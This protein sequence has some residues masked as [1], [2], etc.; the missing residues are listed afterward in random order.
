MRINKSIGYNVQFG[1]AFYA[2]AITM[3]L[4]SNNGLQELLL[5]NK[6]PANED[7]YE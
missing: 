6:K 4:L 2:S 1:S 3:L 5:L 7:T